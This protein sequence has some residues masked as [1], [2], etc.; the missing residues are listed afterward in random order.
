MISFSI[1]FLFNLHS[2]WAT[3]LSS[4]R[5]GDGLMVPLSFL[6]GFVLTAVFGSFCC[7][8]LQGLGLDSRAVGFKTLQMYSHG[9]TRLVMEPVDSFHLRD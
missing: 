7:F 3:L 2:F 5:E 6:G 1:G 8:I 9:S 4:Q